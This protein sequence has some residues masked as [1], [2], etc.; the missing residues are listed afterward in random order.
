MMPEQLP[1]DYK[2]GE[3]RGQL[4]KVFSPQV[5]HAGNDGYITKPIGL[6]IFPG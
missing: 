4:V 5:N 6:S 1:S 2:S 3:S